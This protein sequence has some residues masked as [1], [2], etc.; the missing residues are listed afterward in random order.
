MVLV[1][2]VGVEVGVVVVVEVGVGVGVVVVVVLSGGVV[3]VSCR[4]G[5]LS[6]VVLLPVVLLDPG[7]SGVCRPRRSGRRGVSGPVPIPGVGGLWS[8]D[9]GS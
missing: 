7:I 1:L 8:C 3:V 6:A 4:T 2:V 9:T 5:V